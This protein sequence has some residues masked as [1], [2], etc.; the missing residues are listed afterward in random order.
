MLRPIADPKKAPAEASEKD[1]ATARKAELTRILARQNRR[2]SIV[3]P[4]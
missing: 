1:Y 3:M 4:S 2:R